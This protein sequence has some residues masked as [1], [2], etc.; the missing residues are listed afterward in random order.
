M[1]PHLAY[2]PPVQ[3]PIAEVPGVWLCKWQNAQGYYDM[4]EGDTPQE[5]YNA[6]VLEIKR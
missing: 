3:G 6:M 4:A 1:K 2:Y 5:A